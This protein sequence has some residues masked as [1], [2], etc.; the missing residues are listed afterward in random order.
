MRRSRFSMPYAEA[1]TS[2][3][4]ARVLRRGRDTVHVV[5]D[6]SR[7]G[8]VPVAT[9]LFA[10]T[11]LPSGAFDEPMQMSR[12]GAQLRA[13]SGELAGSAYMSAAG[14]RVIEADGG[15]SCM[16]LPRERNEAR[17]GRVHDGALLGLVDTCA[18]IAAF[19]GTGLEERPPSATVTLS[20]AWAGALD[21]DLVA[22]AR[23]VGHAGGTYTCEAE[24]WS[25]DDRRTRAAALVC[26][27][28]AGRT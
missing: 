6:A 5:V 17:P 23:H 7:V 26:F 9:A 22:G 2:I 20:A 3:A 1:T 19:A 11:V 24:A 16:L 15:W 18:A 10:C 8:G 27:R 13:T 25:A 21:G 4:D 28:V 14:A 12:A